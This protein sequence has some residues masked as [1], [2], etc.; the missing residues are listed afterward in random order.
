MSAK[1]ISFVKIQRRSLKPTKIVVTA[2]NS[3]APPRR[4]T[5]VSTIYG[6]L[7]ETSETEQLCKRLGMTRDDV[8]HLRRKFDDEDGSHSDTVTIRGFF[9]LINDDK[10]FERSQILTKELLRLGN[11]TPSTGRVTFDQFLRVVCTFAAF[12]ETELW[13][14]FYDSFF[15]GGIATV[16]ARKLGEVLQA[17]GNSYA[18][19]IEVAARHLGTNT[20]SPLTGLPPTLTFDDFEELV[21]RNPVVFY[22]LVQ[23]Q[24]NVRSRSLGEKYWMRKVREQELIKPLLAYQQLNQGRLPR[25]KLKDRV[26][27]IMFGGTTVMARART[28]ARRQYLDEMK[29]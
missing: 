23:L 11:V 25:L 5:L 19:N 20:V 13:R 24:R 27:N 10:A 26:V 18:R 28:L 17:A 4:E 6:R 7:L 21:R 22:P 1:R 8:R 3:Q 15:A 2:T 14:F 29:R 12:S 9:H 16:N